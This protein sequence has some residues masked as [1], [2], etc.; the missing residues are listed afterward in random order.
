MTVRAGVVESA[1]SAVQRLPTVCFSRPLAEPGVPVTEHRAL[2]RISVD[3]I[4][5]A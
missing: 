2:H 4:Q 3:V 1:W 5:A